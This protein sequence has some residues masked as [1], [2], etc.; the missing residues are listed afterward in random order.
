MSKDIEMQL[1]CDRYKKVFRDVNHVEHVL[2]V[3]GQIRY[4]RG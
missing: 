1:K 4:R 3:K 2:R